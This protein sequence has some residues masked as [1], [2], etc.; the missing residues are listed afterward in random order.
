MRPS[1]PNLLERAVRRPVDPR[2]RAQALRPSAPG[3]PARGSGHRHRGSRSSRRSRDRAPCS[4]RGRCHGLASTPSS[5]CVPCCRSMISACRRSRPVHDD[6]SSAGCVCSN[7]LSSARCIVAAPLRTAMTTEIRGVGS[8]IAGR[9]PTGPCENATDDA[10]ITQIPDP[11]PRRGYRASTRPG[12]ASDASGRAGPR[13]DRQR[14][15]WLDRPDRAHHRRTGSPTAAV[16][17]RTSPSTSDS[18]SAPAAPSTRSTRRRARSPIVAA[19]TRPARPR[20]HFMPVGLWSED[21][22]LRFFAPRDPAHVSHSVVNLQRT[23]DYFEA[24]VR[25]IPTPDGRARPRSDR[26]AQARHRGRR[27]PGRPVDARA[28]HPPDRRCASRS[29]SPSGRGRSG[30]RSGGSVGGLRPGRRR[31]LEPDVHPAQTSVDWRPAAARRPSR[32]RFDRRPAA[33]DVRRDRPQRRAVHALHAAVALPVRP[34]DHR[35]R[36]RGPRRK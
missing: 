27:A 7:T 5:R 28:R 12:P 15:R 29:T 11:T 3:H 9:I 30:G 26:P 16:S 34:R 20:F 18:S 19:T 33:G 31:S 25:S 22:V 4:R 2:C 13:E 1:R 21:T 6:S 36:G 17:A 14:L 32:R 35:R 23:E 24:P 10:A 8:V